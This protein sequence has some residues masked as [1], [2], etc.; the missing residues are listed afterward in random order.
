MKRFPPPIES[1]LALRQ[2]KK[3]AWRCGS[4]LAALLLL[5][6]CGDSQKPTASVPDDAAVAEIGVSVAK[7]LMESLGGQLKA[8]LEAG[9]PVAAIEVCRSVA[10]PL[11]AA[12]ADSRE[13]VSVRRTTLKPR[14]P[15]N[16]PDETD[17]EVLEAMAAAETPQP[18][19]RREGAAARY[20]QPLVVQETC[21]KC[22]GEPTSFPA[23]LRETLA[24][25][26]P[27]DA[28]TGYALGDLRGAIRVEIAAP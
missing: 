8:A 13:G 9:G 3:P 17:R 24:L 27:D 18:A 26:Y 5:S 6:S 19:I 22:H 10:L 15:A 11:T 14:N 1:D 7:S 12:A 4:A 28:A 16:A 21:L 25:R 20:Y 2:P 23:E